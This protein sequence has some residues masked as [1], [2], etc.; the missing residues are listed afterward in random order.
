M[1]R[2]S[3]SRSRPGWTTARALVRGAGSARVRR[4]CC[5]WSP[6]SSVVER[7]LRSC[8]AGSRRVTMH[9]ADPTTRRPSRPPYPSPRDDLAS[10]RPDVGGGDRDRRGRYVHPHG[11]AHGTRRW[12]IR[13]AKPRRIGPYQPCRKTP[14]GTQLLAVAGVLARKGATNAMLRHARGRWFETTAAHLKRVPLAGTLL[15]S[16]GAL[17]GQAGAAGVGSSGVSCPRTRVATADRT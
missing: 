17:A 8:A 2:S 9:R 4:S 13:W 12:A 11:L 15:G 16:V 10:G 6:A 14:A 3:R 1:A 7:I 5:R